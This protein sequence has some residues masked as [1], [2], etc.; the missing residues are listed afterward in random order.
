MG[1]FDWLGSIGSSAISAGASV[2]TTKM[3][4][5]AAKAQQEREQ[6]FN[7]EQA[8]LNREWQTSEREAQNQWNLDQWNRTNEYNSLSAQIE[9]ALAAGVNPNAVIGNGAGVAS[10]PAQASNIG[11]GA[12]ANTSSIAGNILDAY[13]N[14]GPRAA[15]TMQGVASAVGTSIDNRTRDWLNRKKAAQIDANIDNMVKDGI[16]KSEEA[17]LIRKNAS[18]IDRINEAN[19]E[20]IYTECANLLSEMH[21]NYQNSRVA[22]ATVDEVKA[23]TTLMEEQ[24]ETERKKQNVL[25][26][27]FTKEKFFNYFRKVT[28]LDP[29]TTILPAA[30]QLAK[31]RKN[32]DGANLSD[33]DILEA[34]AIMCSPQIVAGV[35]NFTGWLRNIF[36]NRKQKTGSGPQQPQYVVINPTQ[37]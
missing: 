8:L 24:A 5:D 10:S 9:R 26:E 20:K 37:Q 23:H 6:Q 2:A 7:A 14:L 28:G 29:N 17:Q 19:M 27:E 32:E 33:E 16:L 22:D 1:A 11:S 34:C 31:Q 30:V 36:G 21:L 12:Q 35:A 18:W 3:G 15:E 13:S 25:R 4:I